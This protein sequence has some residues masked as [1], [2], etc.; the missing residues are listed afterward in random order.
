ME[1]DRL[2]QGDQREVRYVVRREDDGMKHFWCYGM[3]DT[4]PERFKCYTSSVIIENCLSM[5]LDDI[6]KRLYTRGIT[7][8][9]Y[10]IPEM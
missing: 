4:C 3:C 10:E 7:V 6:M 2:W 1:Q 9:K 8:K 5:T